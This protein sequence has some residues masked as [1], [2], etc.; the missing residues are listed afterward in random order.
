MCVQNALHEF[1]VKSNGI[2]KQCRERDSTNTFVHTICQIK[3]N[4]CH[5]LK[6]KFNRH[7]QIIES[8]KKEVQQKIKCRTKDT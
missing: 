3:N 2:L 4:A 1:Q 7:S 6:S 5:Q 8:N